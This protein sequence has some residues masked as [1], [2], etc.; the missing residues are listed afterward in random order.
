L[1]GDANLLV[2]PNIDAANIAYNLLKTAAGNN[3]AIGPVLLG[4]A[5]PVH[6]LTASATV[7]RIVNMTALTVADINASRVA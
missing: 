4:A 6:I 7:R 1:S 3:V 5:K 2:C